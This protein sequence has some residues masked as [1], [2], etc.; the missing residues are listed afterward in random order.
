MTANQA[1]EIAHD[2]IF[3]AQLADTSS[4]ADLGELVLFTYGRQASADVELDGPAEAVA[5]VRTAPI[6][7]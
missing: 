1:P 6:G 5:A 7:I 2:A 3:G 4:C